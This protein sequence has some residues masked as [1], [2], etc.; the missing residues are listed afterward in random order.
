MREDL[1]DLP[2]EEPA[3]D[4]EL[5]VREAP[6]GVSDT[7]ARAAE[8]RV[9]TV[10]ELTAAIREALES[11]FFEVFVEGEISNC[12]VWNTGHMYFSLKD[13]RAQVK[14]IMFRSAL[15]Y[16]KFKP[17]DGLHVIARGRVSVYEPKGE[18]QFV[19]EHLEPHGFGA[20]QVAF[21]Q[22]KKKLQAE[23]LFDGARK[24][25]LP[26]L[27]R[28]I[29]I[30]TSL[31][32][33]ALRDIIQ[34]LRRRY[35]NAHLVIRPTRV[36]GEGAA[37]EIAHA[38]R[39]IGRVAGVDV[40]IVGRGGGSAEDLWAFNEE[41]V[42]RAIAAAPMP[43]ISAVGHEVDY[44]IA[45]FVADLR[46]PTPS[47]AAEI[48]VK[49]KEE[50]CS[51][52]D[53]LRDRLRASMRHDLQQRRGRVHALLARRGFG[54][55]TGRIGM[56]GR[57]AAE[58]SHALAHATREHVARRE[59]QLTRARLRLE[60]LDLRRRLAL[61]RGRLV[62]ADG[63]MTAAASRRQQ[64]LDGRLRALA[65]QLETLSPLG[66][67]SRG[68]ALAWNADRSAIIRTAEAVT[69]GDRVHVT[70]QHGELSCDVVSVSD[71]H[72]RA[73]NGT[74]EPENPEPRR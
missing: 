43:I 3:P 20:R 58:L 51:R 72:P 4:P 30:V 47:A 41:P 46:A 38:V 65:G 70:L 61:V 1:F 18:Y 67:L 32:G 35:P 28:K 36:Q 11:R 74:P 37:A 19:C 59:R 9:I 24:R 42:A 40:A 16:L 57:H 15:R 2:F 12:K 17:E 6:P 26:V 7:S 50:Y 68:Y 34:V 53:R 14:A 8:R 60:S 23:G 27:P 63:K 33:A 71:T 64:R 22:L 62:A 66:V 54:A 48:V 49:A 52:I 21:E 55:F 10:S 69:P 44:T 5:E 39:A 31:D 29:G 73:G 13:E 25:P 45:D 56:R